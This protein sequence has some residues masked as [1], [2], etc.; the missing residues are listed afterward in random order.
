MKS[1]LIKMDLVI[2]K[3]E[4]VTQKVDLGAV[5][6]NKGNFCVVIERKLR[7]Q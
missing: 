2:A 6:S 7:F 3:V 1:V 4:L 5:T